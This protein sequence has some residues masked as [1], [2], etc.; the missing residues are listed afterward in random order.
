VA[1][2]WVWVDLTTLGEITELEL[3]FESPIEEL[4]VLLIDNV[5]VSRDYRPNTDY[6]TIALLPK[7]SEYIPDAAEI[8]SSQLEFLT[9]RREPVTFVSH[10]GGIVSD[11]E[12][13]EEW[14]LAADLLKPIMRRMPTGI[15][16]GPGDIPEEEDPSVGSELY[17]DSFDIPTSLVSRQSGVSEDGF[18]SYR[19]F[20]TPVG[21]ILSL[22]L[23]VDAAGETL[24]WAQ[25]VIYTNR[26][27]P[28]LVT[29]ARY[30]NIL[31]G[32]PRRHTD[33]ALA[34]DP[35]T[36]DPRSPEEIWQTLVWRNQQIFL[37]ASGEGSREAVT[38]SRN[39]GEKQVVE[40][41]VSYENRPAGGEG[42]LRLLR[43]YPGRNELRT[44]TYSPFLDM[45]EQ[46]PD[47][48]F[49]LPVDI[50]GPLG[51]E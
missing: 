22:H 50:S 7:T 9:S 30:L 11:P 25:T 18:S 39:R 24:K 20:D 16:I 26:G 8:L 34:G 3:T 10:L 13:E 5:T 43:F 2:Q 48:T 27:L 40:M 44:V 32:T 38:T 47:S 15:V 49:V 35:E 36:W 12:S 33:P 37:V 42:F 45:Y 23:G 28:T 51:I 17:L 29:T 31:G 46:D 6:F 1:D 21:E 4:P 41:L 14:E 19:V